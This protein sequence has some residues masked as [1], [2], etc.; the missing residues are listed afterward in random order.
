MTLITFTSDF[1]LSDH[2]VAQFKARIFTA[3]PEARIVDIS[4]EI[5]AFNL[6]HLSHTLGSVFRD[7][8]KGTVHLIGGSSRHDNQSDYLVAQIDGHLFVAPDNGVL[9]LISDQPIHEVYKLQ[10]EKNAYREIALAA[11][12]LAK[13]DSPDQL[14]SATTEFKQYLKRKSRA[15]K[16]EISGHVI[17][18]DHFGNL[19]TNIEKVDFDILSRDRNFTIYFAREKQNEVQRQMTEVDPGDVFVMFNNE[20]KLMIGINQGSGTQLLGL[21][22]DSPITIQFED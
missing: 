10:A 13:G 11:A 2:Y 5:K 3:Y 19:I 8:P 1:G 20:E 4:H 7:F 16:K 14:G 15:T 18:I 6:A 9:S 17:H 21:E 22:Y 12:R